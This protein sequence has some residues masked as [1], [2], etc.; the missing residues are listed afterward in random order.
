VSLIVSALPAPSQETALIPEG[1]IPVASSTQ[2]DCSGFL[3]EQPVPPELFVAGGSDDDFHSRV[4][5]FVMG[6]TIFIRERHVG[7][8][9]VGTDFMVVRPAKYLFETERYSGEARD[10]RKLGK[11]YENVAHVLVTHEGP[12][13]VLAKV[14]SSCEPI[15]PGD[16]LVPFQAR[17]IPVHTLSPPL[18][19]F[20]PSGKSN[21]QGRITASRDNFGFLGQENIIHLSV[22]E[23]D[24]AR[25]GQRYR[26]YKVLPPHPTGLLTAEKTPPETIGEAIVIF[27]EQKSSVAIIVSSYR[28]VSSGDYVVAE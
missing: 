6:E 8:I 25:P 22:G 7:D 5:Q 17:D 13:G 9:D 11:P 24:G 28:E 20:P 15:M 10:L 23:N 14:L 21:Q 2:A 12:D 1:T 18:D 4:R 3:A 19:H 26:I 16:A 27:T